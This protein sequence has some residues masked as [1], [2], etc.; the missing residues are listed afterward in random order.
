MLK[1][2]DDSRLDLCPSVEGSGRV[3]VIVPHG[4]LY[5][6]GAEGRI[7]QAMIEEDLLE[8]VD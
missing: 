4:V 5:R 1:D 2:F 6:G 7:R 8:S 3:G